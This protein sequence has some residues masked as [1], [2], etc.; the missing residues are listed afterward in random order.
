M[1]VTP[2][3][4]QQWFIAFIS[5]S[6][7]SV[8]G[9]L[10]WHLLS[11]QLSTRLTPLLIIGSIVGMSILLLSVLIWLRLMLAHYVWFNIGIVLLPLAVSSIVLLPIAPA[12][13][14]PLVWCI[15]L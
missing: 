6:S 1:G 10:F 5:L 13:S 2:L 7:S 9:A 4:K 11:V 15:S 12:F 3:T 14:L 8:I